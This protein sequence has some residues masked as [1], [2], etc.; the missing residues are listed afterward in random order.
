MV[1]HTF[2]TESRGCSHL[3]SLSVADTIPDANFY[4]V[5]AALPQLAELQ[6]SFFEWEE[7]TLSTT[8]EFLLS[9][10]RYVNI[11][12]DD[13]APVSHSYDLLPSL[14]T[15]GLLF[16]HCSGAPD[17]TRI[18]AGAPFQEMLQERYGFARQRSVLQSVYFLLSGNPIEVSR[19]VVNNY[20]GLRS[21]G[22]DILAMNIV[23][24]DGSPFGTPRD[25]LSAK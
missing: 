9:L 3:R 11:N 7:H 22:L 20:N 24:T 19:E 5:L 13:Q 12:A 18:V 15:F 16:N 25:I 17:L 21:L 6:L 23:Y 2:L 1:I 10:T 8:E 4:A 14:T